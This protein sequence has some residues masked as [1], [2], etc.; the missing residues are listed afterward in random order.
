MKRSAPRSAQAP[1]PCW[2]APCWA[3]GADLARK[4]RQERGRRERGRNHG[5]GR[6]EPPYFIFGATFWHLPLLCASCL[7]R[8]DIYIVTFLIYLFF[9]SPFTEAGPSL[10]R[11]MHGMRAFGQ[12]SSTIK[13]PIRPLASRPITCV[14]RKLAC[15]PSSSRSSRKT[16]VAAAATCGRGWARASSPPSP[17]L[18]P[19]CCGRHA[20][21]SGP[22]LYRGTGRVSASVPAA[23]ATGRGSFSV[24]AAAA[25]APHGCGWES[26]SPSPLPPSPAF[27]LP[28]VH[29]EYEPARLEA[30]LRNHV[31][32]GATT[33]VGFDLEW[34]P[35]GFYGG[36]GRPAL[37]SE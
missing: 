37:V 16:N 6:P 11:P 19:H 34:R 15:L 14:K 23:A 21:S 22:R 18:S 31:P 2:R 1:A 32:P 30:L 3:T 9:A 24:P 17:A 28:P 29:L 27:Q 25:T 35:M 13:Q 4:G 26:A 36:D 7:I 33:A 20:F 10:T 12:M 5:G 8:T